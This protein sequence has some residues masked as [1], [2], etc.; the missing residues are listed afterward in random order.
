M[1]AENQILK[2][3]LLQV[4]SYQ[5]SVKKADGYDFNQSNNFVPKLQAPSSGSPTQ[6]SLPYHQEN[7]FYNDPM[8]Y[9]SS[10]Y[11]SHQDTNVNDFNSYNYDFGQNN[12]DYNNQNTNDGADQQAIDDIDDFLKE[13]GF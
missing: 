2:S 13:D 11:D 5:S 9:A 1:D 12:Y 7:N 10:K 6:E 3:K 8:D 4:E